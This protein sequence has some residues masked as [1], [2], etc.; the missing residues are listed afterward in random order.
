M[1]LESFQ[2]VY[3]LVAL[4]LA[5]LPWLSQRCFLVVEC[6]QKSAWT[7]LAEWLILYGVVGAMGYLLE[8]RLLGTNHAQGWEFYA[9]TASL[10]MVFA[11]PGF[12]YRHV[13]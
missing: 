9:V 2:W 8:Q 4:V 11:F 6:A 10:F 3:L 13:R 12:V 5:N 1:S 7:R